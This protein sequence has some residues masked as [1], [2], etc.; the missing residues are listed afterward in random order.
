MMLLIETWERA[1]SLRVNKFRTT[2]GYLS[3]ATVEG[4]VV[5]TPLGAASAR[6]MVLPLDHE[7]WAAPALHGRLS[8]AQ[9]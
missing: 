7:A 6:L 9:V 4:L 2:L 1:I 5:H 3:G 8:G